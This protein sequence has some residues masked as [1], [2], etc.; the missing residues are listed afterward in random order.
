[1]SVLSNS[2]KSVTYKVVKGLKMCH[3]LRI[4]TVSNANNNIIHSKKVIHRTYYH[5]LIKSM[6][7]SFKKI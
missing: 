5:Y 2:A 1:M 3:K 6:V 4:I 7:A